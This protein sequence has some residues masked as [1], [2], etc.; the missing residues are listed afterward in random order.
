MML[1]GYN[2]YMTQDTISIAVY[3]YNSIV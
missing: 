3:M 1:H 2:K